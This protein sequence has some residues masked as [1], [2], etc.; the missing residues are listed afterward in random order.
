MKFRILFTLL[1]AWTCSVQAQNRLSFDEA[2]Q[3]TLA[4]NYDI[5]MAQ[6]NEEIAENNAS[7]ANNDFLPT[8]SANGA[9]NWTYYEG[10]NRLI[11]ETRSFD[12]NNSYNYNASAVVNYT[13]FNGGGRK[14]AYLQS[15]GNLEL[16]RLQLQQVIQNTVLELSRI[17][18]E[19]ARREEN[20][21]SLRNSVEISRERFKRAEYRYEY[22]QA[23]R[24]DVLNARV[25]LNT[26][27]IALVTGIQELENLK[28]NLNYIM[29][30]E[31]T[32]ELTVD[33][34][35]ELKQG[36]I[37]E[38]VLSSTEKK[39]LQLKLAESNIEINQ[40]AIGASKSNWLPTLG[41]NA[42]YQYR[43][44]DD[45]NGA[46]LIGSQNYGPQA[47]L[48]L[49]WTLFSGR[50]NVQVK[51][52]KLNLKNQ[53]IEQR[54]LEQSVKSEALNAFANYKNLLFVLGSQTDNVET[55]RDNFKR[56]EDSYNLGQINSIEFRQAQ[57]N[58]L[59]AE[60]AFSTAKY[61]AKN[62]ELQVLA[63]MGVLVE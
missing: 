46:F 10:E 13:L 4:N 62:A 61:D 41:A 3:L 19:V 16:S 32:K 42:G 25:D 22:G 35:V 57:L 7:R 58:L 34:R 50:N 45:P 53:Q 15:K 37:E 43:G 52:A 11:T 18:Y 28:R 59:N 5:L 8:V 31:V 17:Y 9:Y 23:K 12:A 1:L 63:V 38:E 2:L 33:N 55:A 26:D 21:I 6:V 47:G 60:Q 39:N 27:S 40:Y 51:N 14:Y 30:Q 20:L 49:N 24:L 36:L 48:S 29:G 56:S 54:S 44:T